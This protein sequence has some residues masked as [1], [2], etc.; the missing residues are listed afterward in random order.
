MM[1]CVG[2]LIV[3]NSIHVVKLTQAGGRR[4]ET[5]GWSGDVKRR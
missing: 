4:A 5:G 3:S 2:P 1:A